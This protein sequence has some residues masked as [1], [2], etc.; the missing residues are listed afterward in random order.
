M[1]LTS[2]STDKE[3]GEFALGDLSCWLA[4]PRMAERHMTCLARLRLYDW[5]RVSRGYFLL[6]VATLISAP[7]I[8]R[9]ECRA[10]EWPPEAVLTEWS[11]NTALVQSS[12]A[13]ETGLG[14][15]TASTPQQIWV[16]VPAH[17]LFGDAI[18]PHLEEY[19][20]GIRVR[21]RGQAGDSEL[22]ESPNLRAAF[23]PKG[24]VALVC[25]KRVGLLPMISDYLLGAPVIGDEIRL[26][27][28]PGEPG[29]PSSKGGATIQAVRRDLLQT[30]AGA[31]LIVGDLGGVP[32]QSGAVAYSVRG[33]IGLYIGPG[34]NGGS[35]VISIDAIRAFAEDAA[36]PWSLQNNEFYDC[37]QLRSVCASSESGSVPADLYL[38][39]VFTDQR[40]TLARD[41]CTQVPEGRYSTRPSLRALSCEP[42]RIRVFEA[43]TPL[44]LAVHCN[45]DL[46]GKSWQSTAGVLTCMS[47]EPGHFDC[48]GLD[49]L[50]FG[51]FAGVASVRGESVTLRGSF[52]LAG[53]TGLE[54][55]ADLK[56]D[57]DGALAGFLRPRGASAVTITL[58]VEED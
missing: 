5:G 27:G 58:R 51:A 17:V 41:K 13:E 39:N 44:N 11:A 43:Q 42:S 7:S 29:R 32:G 38:T 4:G 55:E 54:V 16:A 47:R 37:R 14:F 22:C 10:P 1:N 6:L 30:K 57:E 52:S 20:A 28:L 3:G 35:R 19:A 2:F 53:A 36:A 18:A 31:D 49:R 33:V 9:A 50:G 24:D 40:A 26:L 23:G 46:A 12:K 25:L 34:E 8:A 56:L 48:L 15:V 21:L 45:I